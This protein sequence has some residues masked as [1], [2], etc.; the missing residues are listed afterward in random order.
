MLP[1]PIR[2]QRVM[3]RDKISREEVLNRMNHQISQTV[4]MRLC[5]YVVMNDEQQL[6]IP[7]ILKIHEELSR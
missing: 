1:M 6:L 7:Q 5:D 4:K 3:Q 2:I